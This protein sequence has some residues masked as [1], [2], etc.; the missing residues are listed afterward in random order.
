METI[1]RQLR[2]SRKIYTGF[3]DDYTPDQ[4]NRVPP[5]FNNNLIWNIGHVIVAQQS[6][7]YHQS[8]LPMHI[9][10]GM[11]ARYR[12]GTRPDG[13]ATREEADQLRA[14]L[15]SLIDQTESDLSA[16]R[17]TTYQERMTRMGFLLSNLE[18]AL[19]FNNYHEGLHLG[20]MMSLRKFV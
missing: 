16:G 13:N 19:A 3:L 2:I 5:G 1:L 11:V 6:L 4:L 7:I 20:Y 9:P 18:E 17:F 14:L 8:G 12:P 15:T 10:D